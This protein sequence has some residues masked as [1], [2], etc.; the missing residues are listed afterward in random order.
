MSRVTFVQLRSADDVT[1]VVHMRWIL[2]VLVLALAGCGDE[3]ADEG[4][5]WKDDP[6]LVECM[7]R[8][9]EFAQESPYPPDMTLDEWVAEFCDL[10]GCPTET[11]CVIAYCVTRESCARE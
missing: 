2:M 4:T 7:T 11:D 1:T 10:E 8:D 3:R 5:T 9:Y 6:E